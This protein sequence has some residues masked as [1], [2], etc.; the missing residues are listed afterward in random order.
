MRRK[1]AQSTQERGEKL[2]PSFC[3]SKN[4]EVF[5][6]HWLSAADSAGAFRCRLGGRT[7]FKGLSGNNVL[8]TF[9][10]LCAVS[11]VYASDH[12]AA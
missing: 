11:C 8:W 6:E 10:A 1:P 3:E 7:A 5:L 12:Q 9:D 4:A 2:S